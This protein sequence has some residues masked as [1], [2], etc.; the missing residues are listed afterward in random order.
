[1]SELVIKDLAVSVEG[2]MI[3]KNINLVIKQGEIHALMG[4]N[5]A[6]K[7]TLGYALMGHPKY[8][9]ERGEILLDGENIV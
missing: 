5:A 8:K 9:I 2:R 3:L 7:T 1:M 4:P 6:G